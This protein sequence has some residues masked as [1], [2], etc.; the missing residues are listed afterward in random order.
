MDQSQNPYGEIACDILNLLSAAANQKEKK[1]AF[2]NR[3]SVP[4]MTNTFCGPHFLFVL[5][6]GAR[7]ITGIP[8]V[9]DTRTLTP[10]TKNTENYH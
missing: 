3:D 9:G 7:S 5:L 6:L 8:V 10:V 2:Q 1:M 4:T